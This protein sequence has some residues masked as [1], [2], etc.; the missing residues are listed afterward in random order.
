MIN[1]GGR[2]RSE[3]FAGYLHQAGKRLAQIGDQKQRARDRQREDQQRRHNDRA[4]LDEQAEATKITVSQKI[5]ISRNGVRIGLSH[6]GEHQKPRM[7]DVVAGLHDARFQHPLR[8]VDRRQRLDRVI[9]LLGE[10]VRRKRGALR[11]RSFSRAR[12]GR[13]RRERPAASVCER[14]RF[15]PI[16]RQQLIGL[17]EI[18]GELPEV[19]VLGVVG[20]LRR[21]DH[22]ADHHRRQR[23]QQAGAEPDDFLG[24][25]GEAKCGQPAACSA[26]RARRRPP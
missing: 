11:D 19:G 20:G 26:S 16:L 23:R 1:S 12:S 2:A 15:R 6:I 17:D 9:E 25:A 21:R 3:R 5:R 14:L 18:G 4:R 7:R 13:S 24:L 10:R 22:Q 8:V